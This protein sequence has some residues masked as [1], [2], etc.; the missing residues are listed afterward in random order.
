[1]LAELTAAIRDSLDLDAVLDRL[2]AA[3]G[4]LVP[5]DAASVMLVKDKDK[6]TYEARSVGYSGGH[7]SES[8]L[9]LVA[10]SDESSTPSP[11]ARRRIVRSV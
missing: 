10:P 7:L 8:G 2:L 4:R 6:G 1:V 5:C 3:A 9:T 11:P